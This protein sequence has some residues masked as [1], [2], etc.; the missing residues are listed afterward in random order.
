[1]TTRLTIVAL[2]SLAIIIPVLCV[3]W[4]YRLWKSDLSLQKAFSLEPKYGVLVLDRNDEIL[5]HRGLR[6]HRAPS[7]KE[8]P[9]H[10]PAAFISAEDRYFY[11]HH[12]FSWRGML[13]SAWVNLMAMRFKQGGSTI[14]QQLVRNIIERREKTLSRKVSEIVMAIFLERQLDKPSIL[15]LYLDRIYFGSGFHGLG[16][17]AQGY[18]GKPAKDLSIAESALLAAIV[19]APAR[20]ALDDERSYRRAIDRQRYVLRR[21]LEDEW[22]KQE[23]YHQALAEAPRVQ[24]LQARWQTHGFSVDWAVLQGSRLGFDSGQ[25]RSLTIQTTIDRSLQEELFSRLKRI[26]KGQPPDLEFACMVLDSKTSETLAVLGSRSYNQSQFNRSYQSRRAVGGLMLPLLRGIGLKFNISF[27]FSNASSF[28]SWQVEQGQLPFEAGAALSQVG[29]GTLRQELLRL[30][31]PH[32]LA[33]WSFVLGFQALSLE[34][35]LSYFSAFRTGQYRRPYLIRQI[36][37]D[38]S[39]VFQKRHRSVAI[40]G[41]QRAKLFKRYIAMS[42]PAWLKGAPTPAIAAIT[43][44]RQNAWLLLLGKRFLLGLW[45]GVDSGQGGHSPDLFREVLTSAHREL[46]KIITGESFGEDSSKEGLHFFWSR[47]LSSKDNDV[48]LPQ[49]ARSKAF[50]RERHRSSL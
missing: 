44:D 43:D 45:V 49:I 17:A 10:V 41:N 9:L 50:G 15:S 2:I 30:K 36:A 34:E 38:S 16:A 18:F 6:R 33:D 5:G 24:S 35:V 11:E 13:R 28:D 8:L 27:P 3:S 22:I 4:G 39:Q 37:Y 42:S 48:F 25:D 47:E 19:K 23:D 46:S 31:W 21:M 7:L 12:G 40:Y 32:R 20:Y 29:L 26:S 14:T 1:M